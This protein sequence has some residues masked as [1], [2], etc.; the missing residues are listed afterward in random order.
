MVTQSR[1]RMVSGWTLA[2]AGSILLN[3]GLFA[4]MPGLIRQTPGMPEKQ[5]ALDP[6]QVIRVKRPEPPPPPKK[7]P[8]PEEKPK[9]AKPV[10]KAVAQPQNV[11]PRIARPR[12]DFQLNP[13][14]PPAPMDLAVPHVETFDMDLPALKSLYTASEL[15]A[16][17]RAVKKL[18]P[19]YPIRAKRRRIQGFVTVA[20]RVTKQGRV[21]NIEILKSEPEGVFDKSV[22]D[23]VARWQF[24]PGTVEGI[25]VAAKAKTTIRFKLEK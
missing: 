21:E 19:L 18:P 1:F 2:L 5:A 10:A 15:D 24:T 8:R 3:L 6:I 22:R 23:C 16:P 17:L 7:K 25:P 20:F 9:P 13:K 4:L 11:R 14:L 12:L